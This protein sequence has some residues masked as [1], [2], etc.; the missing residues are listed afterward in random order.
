MQTTDNNGG[1]Y[2][3]KF[4][5]FAHLFSFLWCRFQSVGCVVPCQ[6][7][8]QMLTLPQHAT[9]VIDARQA[10]KKIVMVRVFLMQLT[11]RESV[12]NARMAIIGRTRLVNA[13]R[14][15]HQL[16]A[17]RTNIMTEH[18]VSFARF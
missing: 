17:Q 2:F 8:R 10:Q 9:T 6:Q 18:H 5:G 12:K 7:R 14:T 13:C 3:Y 16:I 4:P 15:Q 1:F 11:A